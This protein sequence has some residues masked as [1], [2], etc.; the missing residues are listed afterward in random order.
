MLRGS[1]LSGGADSSISLWDLEAA[2][3]NISD[4]AKFEPIG[5]NRRYVEPY[6]LDLYDIRTI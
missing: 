5:T 1:L 6:N 3:L 2:D 4:P